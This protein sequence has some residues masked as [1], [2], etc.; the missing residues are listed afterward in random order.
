MNLTFSLAQGRKKT[1]LDVTRVIPGLQL[2][3][4]VGIL[5]TDLLMP[6]A[7]AVH[8]QLSQNNKA[9]A[10][11]DRE[12]PPLNKITYERAVLFVLG[13]AQK[14]LFTLG[15]D[16]DQIM[17]LIVL[18]RNT[19]ETYCD[20][21]ERAFEG[22]LE[23]SKQR[24]VDHVRAHTEFIG[25]KHKIFLE[26]LQASL[27]MLLSQLEQD[28]SERSMLVHVD[29]IEYALLKATDRFEI[30]D[31]Q[32]ELDAYISTLQRATIR[33]VEGLTDE[34]FLQILCAMCTSYALRGITIGQ[35]HEARIKNLIFEL[36][37]PDGFLS[38]IEK[39]QQSPSGPTE[40][41]RTLSDL[42]FQFMN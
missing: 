39:A 25:Y 3:K 22:E 27:E 30:Q 13:H 9:Y 4:C 40:M 11:R 6:L 41:F 35:D 16:A 29:P 2:P 33:R 32:L 10:L 20:T 18:A 28:H 17:K 26:K 37:G 42:R 36:L 7:D 15:Y 1:G 23:Y 21:L 24:L 38:M 19:E 14:R 12:M 34:D 8:H 5:E 31:E